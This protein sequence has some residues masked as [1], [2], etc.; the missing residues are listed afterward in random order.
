MNKE[1][2]NMEKFE[3]IRKLKIFLNLCSIVN[4][5]VDMVFIKVYSL[6]GKRSR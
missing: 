3:M 1:V 4:D 5:W 6:W 2:I